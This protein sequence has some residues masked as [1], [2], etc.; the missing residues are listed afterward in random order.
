MLVACF[1]DDDGFVTTVLWVT[2]RFA[3][4]SSLT[5]LTAFDSP[6]PTASDGFATVRTLIMIVGFVQNVFWGGGYQP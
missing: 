3:T 2:A 6:G 5:H 1:A 4:N